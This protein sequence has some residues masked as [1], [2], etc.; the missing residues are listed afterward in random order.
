MTTG[1]LHH[2]ELFVSDIDASLRLWSWVL[3][4]LGYKTLDQWDGGQ[5]FR[6]GPTFLA[7]VQVEEKHKDPPYHRKKVGVNHLAFR[8]RSR[9]H[10]DSIT[11]QL[12]ER[13]VKILYEDRHPFAGGDGYYAVFFEDPDRMKVEIVA[14]RQS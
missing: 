1:T 10:V 11:T 13:G 9:E 8:A 6:L 14:P 12:R 7:F 5:S 3:G 4:E 2:I